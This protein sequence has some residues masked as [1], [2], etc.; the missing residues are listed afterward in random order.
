MRGSNLVGNIGMVCADGRVCSGCV[1][2]RDFCLCSL[3]V[4][5]ICLMRHQIQLTGLNDVRND[6]QPVHSHSELAR[7]PVEC[8]LFPLC[9]M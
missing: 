9:V 3:S 4:H 7:I 5:T 1:R 6:V 8:T 2:K